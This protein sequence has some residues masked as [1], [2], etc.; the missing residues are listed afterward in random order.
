M[1]G[2]V[3]RK[4]DR[5]YAVIYEGLDPVTGREI[6]AE[7]KGRDDAARSLSVGAYLTTQWR[8]TIDLDPTTIDVLQAGRHSSPPNAEQSASRTAT[9]CSPPPPANPSIHTPSPRPSNGSSVEPAPRS[10][11]S[12][13]DPW[14]KVYGE[15]MDVTLLYF[16]D[17]PNWQAAEWHLAQSE[18]LSS[19]GRHLGGGRTGRVRWVTQ[20]S[21]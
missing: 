14:I 19:P 20:R 7:V 21:H 5:Y 1:Q 8:R 4:R 12:D 15:H 3:A 2:Y 10:S 17:C 16:E 11:A 6:A 9:R 18:D 13:L